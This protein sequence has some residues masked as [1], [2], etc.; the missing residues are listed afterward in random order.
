MEQLLYE[1][2]PG[3]P[4]LGFGHG[5]GKEKTILPLVLEMSCTAT[6]GEVEANLEAT[7]RRGY[8]PL[9]HYLDAFKGTVS[10]CGSGPSLE[11]TLGELQGDVF[12]VNGS[13]RFLLERGIVPKVCMFWDA[14]EIIAEF[15]I[16]H[17]DVTYFV[18]SRCHPKV[19][20][21]LED[22]K[23]VVWHAGGDHDIDEFL[24]SRKINEP[25]LM[26]GTTG[27][28]RG[29]YLAFALGWRDMHIFGADSCYVEGK[30]HVNGA[31]VVPEG[32]VDI[33][34]GGRW[35]KSTC[36]WAS[37]IEEMKLIYP[38]LTQKE[39]GVSLTAHDEGMFA[40]VV[41]IMRRHPEKA[42]DDAKKLS[43]YMQ[44]KKGKAAPS[45]PGVVDAG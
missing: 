18:A 3:L 35:F 36:Q 16:P 14:A 43:E 9:L 10:L 22:C 20:E 5:E 4:M 7:L 26:G 42:L 44:K 1:P 2:K 30:T 25:M 33:L 21:R 40:W 19:F 31:S 23:V 12:A 17:Q 28:T 37:Q 6:A 13:H 39:V 29:I 8:V 15:A 24:F 38:M 32:L 27:V 34:V 45:A 41:D 11:A